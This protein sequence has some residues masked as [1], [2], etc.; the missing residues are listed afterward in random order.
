[1]KN[2]ID[3]IQYNPIYS[4]DDH[5]S[6]SL[7]PYIH[8]NYDYKLKQANYNGQNSQKKELI[9]IKKA[10]QHAKNINIHL[11]I[12]NVDS[13]FVNKNEKNE[14]FENNFQEPYII[15]KENKGYEVSEYFIKD[16]DCKNYKSIYE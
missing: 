6:D 14:N 10:N 15:Y 4:N 3:K 11:A 12:Q 1:M 13:E 9:Q 5:S 2:Q 16:Y 8:H 7:I